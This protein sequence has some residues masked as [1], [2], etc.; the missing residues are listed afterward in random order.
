MILFNFFS[1][2]KSYTKYG[3]I[4]KNK[5]ASK[6]QRLET[7]DILEKLDAEKSIPELLKRFEIVLESGLQ[8]TKEKEACLN[9]IIKHGAQAQSYVKSYLET[10]KRL[11]WVIRIAEKI[12]PKEELL[13]LLLANLKTDVVEFDDDAMERNLDILFALKDFEDPNIT[14]KISSFLSSRDDDTRIAVLEC[15]E[16]QAEKDLQAR[17]IILNL[18]QNAAN[19]MNSRFT[20]V[21]THMIKKH[22]WL[23]YDK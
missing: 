20:G 6:E 12:F 14:K 23:D 13:Q 9:A 1:K 16:T 5:Q 3:D 2:K 19:D 17:Q 4:L 22:H 15:L 21:V 11:A 8:D 7:I 18:A 10:Q